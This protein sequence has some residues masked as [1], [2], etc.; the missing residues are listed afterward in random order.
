MLQLPPI[1]YGHQLLS[2]TIRTHS[3][4]AIP[5]NIDG[6]ESVTQRGNHSSITFKSSPTTG[7]LDPLS[8][9]KPSVTSVVIPKESINS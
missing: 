4:A 9:R 3:T 2:I 6:E 8:I 7:V 5:L 1:P